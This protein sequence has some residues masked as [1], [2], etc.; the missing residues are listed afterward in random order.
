MPSL[1]TIATNPAGPIKIMLLGDSGSGKTGALASLAFKLKL[2]VYIVDFDGGT[3]ILLDPT[4]LPPEFRRLVHVEVCQDPMKA[5]NGKVF[6]SAAVA[7]QKAS[8]VLNNWPSKGN[9]GTWT[10]KD[11]LVIDSS[12]FAGQ[13]AL[14]F[15]MN[16]NA[17]LAVPPTWQDFKMPQEYVRNMLALIYS[18]AVKCNVIVCTH[19]D[20]RAPPGTTKEEREKQDIFRGYP[21]SVGSALGPSMGRYFNDALMVRDRNIWVNSRDGVELKSSRPGSVKRFYPLATGLA[22]YFTDV[23]GEAKGVVVPITTLTP[24]AAPAT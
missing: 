12:T 11:V 15:H 10:T 7:W 18:D 3:R 6:P 13:A 22:D 9:V 16:L 4:I 21:T 17:K 8:S 19:I 14:N 5:L 24:P 1:D 20:Y 2:N 23:S